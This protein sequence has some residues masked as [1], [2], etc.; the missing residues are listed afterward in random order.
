MAFKVV[1]RDLEVANE[2][3]KESEKELAKYKD[4]ALKFEQEKINQQI[5]TE[6]FRTL[7]K[8]EKEETNQLR[9]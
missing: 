4:K 9:E 1:E 7:L 3:L 8:K 6:A 2:N 5:Q